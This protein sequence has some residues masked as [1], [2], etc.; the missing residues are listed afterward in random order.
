MARDVSGNLHIVRLDFIVEKEITRTRHFYELFI[1][2]HADQVQA[3]Q[4]GP[5]DPELE[6][7]IQKEVEQAVLEFGSIKRIAHAAVLIKAYQTVEYCLTQNRDVLYSC[8]ASDAHQAI[9]EAADDWKKLDSHDDISLDDGLVR[10]F[11][12]VYSVIRSLVKN[13]KPRGFLDFIKHIA[14]FENSD[15]DRVRVKQLTHFEQVD[16]LRVMVNIFKHSNGRIFFGTERKLDEKLK[17]LFQSHFGINHQDE[18]VR[19]EVFCIPYEDINVHES[20]D[21]VEA[22]CKELNHTVGRFFEKTPITPIGI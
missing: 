20:L 22:F 15:G 1:G 9:A 4:E 7:E 6:P 2:A 11:G 12:E 16:L 17:V 10:V 18:D 21:H 13:E 14:M 8:A 3:W 19:D 5:A